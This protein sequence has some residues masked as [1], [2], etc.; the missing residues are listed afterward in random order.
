MR[1]PLIVGSQRDKAL[2]RRRGFSRAKCTC[3]FTC[4]LLS[5]GLGGCGSWGVKSWELFHAAA[6][7]ASH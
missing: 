4:H 6:A 5:R 7:I 2:S 1:D 3:P